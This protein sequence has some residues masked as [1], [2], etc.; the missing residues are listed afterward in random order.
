MPLYKCEKCGRLV[1]I[2][3]KGLCPSC[4]SKELPPKEKKNITVKKKA[5]RGKK[6]V[7][8]E[9]SGFFCSMLEVLSESRMSYTGR[10][11]Y[12]PS[13]CNVCHILP[14]R[15]YKS[16]ATDKDNIVFLTEDEHTRFDRF[17]D[18]LEFDKLENTFP[19]VWNRALSQIKLMLDEGR[20][21]EKGRL[22]NSIIERYNL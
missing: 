18:C 15:W 9:L 17:L 21:Q 11:I 3:S 12:Y 19:I 5:N 16:I 6:N 14:K 10:P 1:P 22:L 20:I 8:P 2:R 13:V 4:R 7:N